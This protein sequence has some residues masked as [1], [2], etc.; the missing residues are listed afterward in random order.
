MKRSIFLGSVAAVTVLLSA[1]SGD[2]TG[3]GNAS[4]TA[5]APDGELVNQVVKT[6]EGGY[7][8]GDPDAPIRL[9]EYG[10]LVC[11]HCRDFEP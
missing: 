7:L 5:A 1:C 3:D 8:M 10:S 11:V 6:K 4:E 2:K 9:T